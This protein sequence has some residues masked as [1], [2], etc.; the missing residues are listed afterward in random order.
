MSLRPLRSRQNLPSTFLFLL[1]EI[2]KEQTCAQTQCRGLGGSSPHARSSVAHA[3]L[4]DLTIKPLTQ[5]SLTSQGRTQMR[6]RRAALVR[7]P[8]YKR[9]VLGSQRLIL[10]ECG[11]NVGGWQSGPRHPRLPTRHVRKPADFTA[12]ICAACPN[13]S[14]P[15]RSGGLQSSKL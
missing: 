10:A 13:K 11:K 9:W 7:C 3:A 14:P 4:T 12:S 8:A 5:L 2:F 6:Q 15:D 1:Y